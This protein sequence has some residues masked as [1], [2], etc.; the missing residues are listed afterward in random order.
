M[1]AVSVVDIEA[2]LVSPEFLADPYPFLHELRERAPVYWSDAI[3]GWLI[4]RYDDV[5]T[6][7]KDTAR[8]SNENRLGKA[9]EYL[10]ADRRARYAAF[11]AH[12]ATKGLLH[13]D[14]PD[15]TRLRAVIN[16]DF[17]PAVVERMRPSIQALVDHL[18]DEAAARGGMDVVPNLAAALP[19]GV[20]A[21]ILGVPACDRH[22]FKRWADMVLGF[23]G[24]NKPSE[25]DLTRA[26]DGLLEMRAY[27]QDMIADRRRR[28]GTDLMAKFVA[29]EAEGGRI[30]EAELV[31]TCV[32]LLTAGH[33]TSLSLIANTIHTLLSHPH[34]AAA[35]RADPGLLP[36]AIEESLR[37]ESP[38]SR[39]SRLMKQDAEL[40]G[41]TLRKGQVVFQMLNAA[42]RDP[43]WFAAPD[44]FDIRRTPNRHVAFGFGAHF[45]VGATLARVEGSIAVGT[46]IRRFPGVRLVAASPEWDLTKRN[47]RVLNTLPVAF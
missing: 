6:T 27:L 29:A 42:N 21:E 17:T 19:V 34:Q 4:T 41:Q 7:F 14:P 23:Q 38:V 39:Q 31:N 1:D 18:L 45:C 22:L 26:Q 13:S 25:A 12:Y 37:Y 46:L 8:F 11:E 28:G 32:T 44:T 35:L 33:E 15:H 20:I 3:G 36:S 9:V 30:S 43:A 40:G 47:S 10:P 2:T 24:V 16:K 5:M